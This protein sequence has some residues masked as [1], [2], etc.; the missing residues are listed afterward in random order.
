MKFVIPLLLVLASGIRAQRPQFEEFEVA[1]IKP[2]A[3]DWRGGRY[4]TMQGAHRFI[5]MNAT[6][7]F[8]LAAAYN[9]NQ[10]SIS[11]GPDWI[12]A[13]RYDIL[14]GTPN[15][16]K[17]T[18]DEQMAMLRKLLTERFSL[19]FHR[20][21]REL[22]IY[23]LSVARGGS[24]LQPSKLPPDAQSVVVNTLYPGKDPGSIEHVLMPAR[25]GT[26]AEFAAVMQRTV[27]DR[28]VVDKTGLTGKYDFDLEWTPDEGQFGGAF[29]VSPAEDSPKPSLFAAVQQ[30]LG[31]RFEAT[32]GRVEVMVMDRVE[33]PSAN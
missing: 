4:I 12:D 27:L 3:Q 21:P 7:K 26:I 9:L 30:Q 18:L 33:R 11:G 28:P 25:N 13:E 14:A 20:E 32:R 16:E 2:T 10:K 29:K 8:L 1:T 19:A 17:P 24:K 6:L 23:E 22:S 31:L 5:V 15:E